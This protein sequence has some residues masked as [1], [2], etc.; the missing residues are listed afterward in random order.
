MPRSL[1]TELQSKLG[2][3]WQIIAMCM[4]GELALLLY[5]DS[6][7]QVYSLRKPNG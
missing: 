6:T 4:Y 7:Y 5:L 2:Y 1:L 3:T